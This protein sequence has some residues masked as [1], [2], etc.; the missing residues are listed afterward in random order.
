MKHSPDVPRLLQI[1]VYLGFLILGLMQYAAFFIGLASVSKGILNHWYVILFVLLSY[2]FRLDLIAAV[3][4][5]YGLWN[6]GLL[7]D[8]QAA[9]VSI[10]FLIT[11]WFLD[12]GMGTTWLKNR[13]RRQEKNSQAKI[14]T[15]TTDSIEQGKS[16]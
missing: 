10:V 12:H 5:F 15:A 1:V 3:F 8:W 11:S 9:A 14:P 13:A 6:S 4:G 16:L 2:M 7:P